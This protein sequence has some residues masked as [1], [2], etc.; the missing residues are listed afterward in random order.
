MSFLGT[1]EL[2]IILVVALVVVGP[3]RLPDLAKNLGK[4]I[5]NFKNATAKM[6]SELNESGAMDEINKLKADMKGMADEINPMK[7]ASYQPQAEQPEAT[8]AA[9]AVAMTESPS[10]AGP[11]PEVEK[12][13]A[14]AN[15]DTDAEHK[16]QQDPLD[17]LMGIKD[18]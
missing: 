15:N 14:T 18:A 5:R 17:E 16:T 11:E 8:A 2:L 4:G 1:Q 10:A 6:R 3:K 12:T 7:P 9:A 13:F